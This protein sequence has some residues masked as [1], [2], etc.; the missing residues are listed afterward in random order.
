MGFKFLGNKIFKSVLIGD[1]AVGKTSIRKSYLGADFKENHLPTIGVELAQTNVEHNGET[2]KYIIWDLAGQ[3][4]FATVRKHYY[5]GCNGIFLVYSAVERDSFHNASKWLVEAFRNIGKL[6]PT[7]VIANKIDLRPNFPKNQ[8][9]TY[10]EG[11]QF[12]DVFGKRLKV[13][14]TFIETS[15]LTG[16]NIKESFAEMLRMMYDEDMKRR[17]EV[18]KEE[19]PEKRS[20]FSFRRYDREV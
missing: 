6:P 16:E 18:E 2:I 20:R 11:K 9:V 17:E 7:V 1:G 8:T 19:E 12:S 15:A 5:Q 4:S 10:E 3:P 14:T 13:D